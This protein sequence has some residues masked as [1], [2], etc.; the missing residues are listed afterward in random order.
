MAGALICGA[1]AANA[2]SRPAVVELFTSE[3]CS[4]CP[5]AEAYVGELAQR[6]D[7]LALTFHV[8]YWDDLGWRDRFGLPESVQRQR[9]YANTLQLS[10]V[11]TPQAVVDGRDS[12]VGSDRI[13]I[14]RAVSETRTGVA[15]SMSMRDGELAID[16]AAQTGAAP[17]EVVLIA[18]Q[19]SAISPIGRGE[20]AGRT[21]QE[22]NIV[23]GFHRLG[24]WDGRSQ[25]YK[26]R[27]DSLPSGATNVAILIQRLGQAPIIGAATMAL[28][29]K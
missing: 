17:S 15:V 19:R 11:F 25:R 24:L 7:V 22:F 28:G 27:V 18:Y 29:V 26:A 4:S 3:G 20:N 14:G 10:S 2:Q 21:I 13:G 16:V 6:A 9:S 8:D 23:R 5:P 1:A 12:Y